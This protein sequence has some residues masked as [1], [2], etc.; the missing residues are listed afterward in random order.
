MTSKKTKVSKSMAAKTKKSAT[1][2][3]TTA[4]VNN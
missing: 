2:A 4:S 1:V 3:A